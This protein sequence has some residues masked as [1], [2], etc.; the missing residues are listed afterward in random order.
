M[1]ARARRA[2]TY[3]GAAHAGRLRQEGKSTVH[4]LTGIAFFERDGE[5]VARCDAADARPTLEFETLRRGLGA[6]GYGHW[7]LQT[8]AM[9][10][11]A[12][13]WHS[14]TGEIE[15]V[16][17][18]REDASC[19][20]EVAAD[21]ACAWLEL[22]PAHGGAAL[23][24]ATVLQ[25]LNDAG[26]V[27]GIDMAALQSAC[28]AGT[29]VRVVVAT[30][31]AP[32][33]GEDTRFELLVA[34]TRDRT[35]KVDESGLID[36]H[37]LGDIPT[38]KAGQALM[39]RHPPTPGVAGC[40]VRGAPMAAIPGHDEA[41]APD[42]VGACIADDDPDLLRAQCSGQP[43]HKQNAVMVEQVLRMK[44]VSIATGN[45]NFDG[46]VE[47]N[48]DVQPGMKVHAT[49]DI[50]VKGLVEGGEL[51]AGGSISVSGGV[52]ARAVLR[53]AQ[54]ASARF[55]ENSSIHAGT[56]IAITDMAAHSDLQALNEVIVGAQSGQRGRLVGGMTRA[57]MRVRTPQLGAAAGG[58]T[59]VQVGVNP[60]LENRHRELVALAEKQK[61]EEDKLGKVF[62]HLNK[63]GDPRGIRDR[64]QAAWK[65]SLD[66]WGKSIAE[67]S[68]LEQQL[69]LTAAACIEVG[70]G[71][72]GEVD[73]VFGKLG[74]R[75]RRSFGAG[76][77]SLTTDGKVVFTDGGGHATELS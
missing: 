17:G 19:K 43:V 3:P 60:A 26:V 75:V 76:A 13:R 14:E 29:A 52:I 6:A 9:L 25:A 77:F 38:V 11:L 18:R 47:V 73:I 57:M 72:A 56:T 41:F 63:H 27:H 49:G 24:P 35:P 32:Q 45:I 40:N 16:L 34:D 5:L 8:E 12:K 22:A 1:V 69:A 54:T 64:V 2:G 36:Y 39:R 48:G 70:T 10:S 23:A 30:A 20:I 15:L 61:A 55:V 46:T 66:V 37:E 68:E 62:Q 51:E 65:Q 71:V 67:K 7:A 33:K 58:L 4:E 74:R 31:T 59:K 44:G 53:A 42:L 21:G 50:I 28:E